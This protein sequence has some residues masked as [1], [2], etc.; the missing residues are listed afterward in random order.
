VS[1][2]HFAFRCSPVRFVYLFI[3]SAAALGFAMVMLGPRFRHRSNRAT[4]T[5]FYCLLVASLFAPLVHGSL[6]YG[7]AAL[8][9]MMGLGWRRLLAWRWSTFRLGWSVP[10]GFLRGGRL[11]RLIILGIAIAGALV[12]L[13]GLLEVCQM[14]QGDIGPGLCRELSRGV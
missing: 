5:G 13:R 3:L 11:A 10:R 8:R 7:Y 6:V 1:G 12:R 2:A 14:W 9:D 4:K